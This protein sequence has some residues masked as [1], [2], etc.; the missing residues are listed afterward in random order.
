MIERIKKLF[1]DEDF[2]KPT[3][4]IFVSSIIVNIFNLLYWFI[5]V[6]VLKAHEYGTLNSLVS[7]FA[8]FSLPVG[9]LQTVTTKFVAQ[10]SAKN[11]LTKVSQLLFYFLKRITALSLILVLLFIL[12]KDFLVGYL[13]LQEPS[14]VLVLGLMLALSLFHPLVLG[15]LQGM[16]RF[17]ALGINSI[18]NVLGK[19]LFGVLLVSLG[20]GVS[21]ALWGFGCSFL[22]AVILG[23]TQIPRSIFKRIKSK[24][25]FNIKDIYKYFIP[26]AVALFCF[27][28]LINMDIVLVKHFFT[29]DEAGI[30]SISQFVGKIVFFLPAA[31]SIVMFPKLTKL[32]SNQEETKK[33]LFK[34]LSLAFILVTAA[35]SF[36]YFFPQF[37][38]KVLTN[39]NFTESIFLAKLF[40]VSMGFFS[41]VYILMFYFLSLHRFIY[42][43]FIAV[44][45][46]LQ[47]IL[48][49]SFHVNMSQVLYVVIANAFLLFISGLLI[50]KGVKK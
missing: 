27:N 38:L 17:L 42:V 48:I 26:T 14:L 1:S 32:Y 50:L 5:M 31:L 33:L 4:I 2:I 43:W 24:L 28:A 13:N 16:H 19:L 21:G 11:E 35:G 44:S 25:E 9:V 6:R 29:A 34:N 41:F 10:F 49:N 36:V 39:T 30:Y 40:V 45:C 23:L 15:F 8:V 22:I 46:V 20:F 37:T 47:F 12:L 7:L 18:V 3:S